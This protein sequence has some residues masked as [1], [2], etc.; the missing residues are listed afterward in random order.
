[1]MKACVFDLDGTLINSLEDLAVSVNWALERNGLKPYPVEDYKYFVG[2]GIYVLIDR[3]IPKQLQ[4]DE[5]KAKIKADFDLHYDS[6]NGDHTVIY[7]GIEE[8]L[9]ELKARGIK[10]GVISN[11][12]DEFATEIVH[13]RFPGMFDLVMGLSDRFPRKP[14]PS[15]LQYMLETFGVKPEETLYAGD[16]NVDVRTGK[17][18]GAT[19]I[20][21]MWGFR[22]LEELTEAGADHIIYHPQELLPFAE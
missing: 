6:H 18:G 5:L 1:M 4:T 20:G 13:E 22:T 16:T 19:T 11:K 7:D 15:A 10:L 2:D 8:M 12:P 3:V 17:N 21:V 14:D 9:A